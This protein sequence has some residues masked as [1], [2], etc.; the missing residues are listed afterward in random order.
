MTSE[1]Q[2]SSTHQLNSLP[3]IIESDSIKQERYTKETFAQLCDNSVKH[4]VLEVFGLSL[5]H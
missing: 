3:N 1:L 4:Q 2:S 5:D